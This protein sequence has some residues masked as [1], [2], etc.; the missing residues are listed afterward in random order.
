MRIS[1]FVAHRS[2][3]SEMLYVSRGRDGGQGVNRTLDTKISASCLLPDPASLA[4]SPKRM[5]AWPRCHS[6]ETQRRTLLVPLDGKTATTPTTVTPAPDLRRTRD[7]RRSSGD[8][9]SDQLEKRI[10]LATARRKE[11]LEADDELVSVEPKRQKLD[12]ADEALEPVREA[13][14]CVIGAFFS[15]NKEDR[16]AKRDEMLRIYSNF[17]K[18]FKE[19]DAVLAELRGGTHPIRPFHW[20]IELPGTLRPPTPKT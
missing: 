16:L 14:A 4:F 7:R 11:I 13:G 9:A 3:A 1:M 6:S 15:S 8:W 19:L 17:P 10:Q 2:P 20:E 12:L 5:T 18:T